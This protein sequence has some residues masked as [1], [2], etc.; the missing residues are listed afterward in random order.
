MQRRQHIEFPPAQAELGEHLV[1]ALPKQRRASPKT[2]DDPHGRKFQIGALAPP[3]RKD[4]GRR[5]LL[6]ALNIGVFQALRFMAA[7]RLPGDWPPWWEPFS[8]FW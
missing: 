7:Y 4:W 2:A 6:S 8:R 3:L 1:K 5:L